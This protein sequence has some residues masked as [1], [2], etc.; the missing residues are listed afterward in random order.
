LIETE[1]KAEAE[2]QA[3]SDP[4]CSSVGCTQFKHKR[5][6]MGY[7]MNY[8]VPNFGVDYDIRDTQESIFNYAPGWKFPTG[9]KKH[10]NVAKDTLYNF[11]PIID[12][13]IRTT[14]KNLK[15]A[16]STLNHH[17][18]IEDLQTTADIN[19]D[20]SSDPICSSAGCTQY[21]FGK[22]TRGLGYDIDYG[23][24]HFG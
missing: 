13:D 16:E 23:V 17:W 20:A 24:P 3:T 5:S 9:D 12:A 8:F 4:I 6:A 1:A 10:H 11:D 19:A 21:Q 18:V 14:Q 15:D 2:A 22:K 7:P